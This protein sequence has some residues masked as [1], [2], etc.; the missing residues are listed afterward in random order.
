[1]RTANASV[2]RNRRV[3]RQLLHG[4]RDHGVRC[5]FRKYRYALPFENSI[6]DD[7]VTEKVYNALLSGALPLYIGA[8]DIAD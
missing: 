5:V 8:M 6:E 3:E 1:M 7:Y 4:A 2:A